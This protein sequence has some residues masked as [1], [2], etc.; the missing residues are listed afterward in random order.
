MGLA[1]PL[2]SQNID[3]LCLGQSVHRFC[4]TALLSFV[5]ISN[6]FKPKFEFYIILLYSFI[7]NF[8]IY[9][10]GSLLNI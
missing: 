1:G 3:K 10:Y 4:D 5:W 2:L 7:P 6:L 8:D 9:R